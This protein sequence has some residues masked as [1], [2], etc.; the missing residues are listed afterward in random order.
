MCPQHDPIPFLRH[1]LRAGDVGLVARLARALRSD[2]RYRGRVEAEL[3]D[4]PP[5]GSAHTTP[6]GRLLDQLLVQLRPPHHN[7][8]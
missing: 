1:V 8:R 4:L 2:P 5:P 7:P 3:R 6:G